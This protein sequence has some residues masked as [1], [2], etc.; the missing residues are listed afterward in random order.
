MPLLAKDADLILEIFT[1]FIRLFICVGRLGVWGFV[2][3]VGSFFRARNTFFACLFVL[4]STFNCVHNCFTAVTVRQEPSRIVAVRNNLATRLGSSRSDNFFRG[5][6]TLPEVHFRYP[7]SR[8][9]F[10]CEGRD[11]R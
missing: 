7:F 2:M 6:C 3:F 5:R 9:D 4:D 10:R 11:N 1:H 8:H